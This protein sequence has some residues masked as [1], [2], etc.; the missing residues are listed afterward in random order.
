M[1]CLISKIKLNRLESYFNSSFQNVLQDARL[2][3]ETLNKFLTQRIAWIYQGKFRVYPTTPL[4]Y[5]PLQLR[6]KV[7]VFLYHNEEDAKARCHLRNR[8]S[9][10]LAKLGHLE[11]ANFS[12]YNWLMAQ[13]VINT[14]FAESSH[15]RH[16]LHSQSMPANLRN[17]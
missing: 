7:Y 13:D 10:T 1:V 6:L 4:D 14:H 3:T 12:V 9:V 16:S 11:L 8:I 17:D 5:L 2:E 15:L